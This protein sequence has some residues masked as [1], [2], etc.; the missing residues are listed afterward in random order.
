MPIEP[1]I[2][3][4][5]GGV[6]TDQAERI[7]NAKLNQTADAITEKLA[8]VA[9]QTN[10]FAQNDAATG[11]LT[12][13]HLGGTVRAGL[14]VL[15]GSVSLVATATNYVEIDTTTGV[16]SVNQTGF[17]LTKVALRKL[18][19]DGGSITTNTDVRTWVV[20]GAIP[21]T[22]LT[23]V[24]TGSTT[25]LGVIMLAADGSATSGR[26]PQANDVRMSDPRVP[27]ILQMSDASAANN[28]LYYSTDLSKLVYKD[29]A[30]VV[31]LLY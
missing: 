24:P 23:G 15:A 9:Q 21:W 2:F 18:V 22:N 14:Q 1:Y 10:Q 28:T 13:A 11:G 27:K 7:T 8:G 17:T 20:G 4:I 31:N 12:W 29:F 6:R 5:V 25:N 16:V 19:C 30:G 3:G 26:A